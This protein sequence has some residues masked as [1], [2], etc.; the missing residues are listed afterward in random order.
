[1]DELFE[2]NFDQWE[3]PYPPLISF[4]SDLVPFFQKLMK[5]YESLFIPE[6]LEFAFPA[7]EEVQEHIMNTLSDLEFFQ[8]QSGADS[9]RR[10]N[11]RE[12]LVFH[13][14]SGPQAKFKLGNI[15]YWKKRFL[16]TPVGQVLVSLLKS[17]DVVLDSLLQAIGASHA[18]KE[19]KDG[20]MNVV[21]NVPGEPQPI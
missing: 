6:R 15:N 20:L 1:M 2:F 18:I 11:V 3:D 16:V 8:A 10:F 12:R 21:D 5:N 7:F 13:G 14:L 9:T 17:I 19:F 4:V